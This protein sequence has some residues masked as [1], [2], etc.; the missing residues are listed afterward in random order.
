MRGIKFRGFNP[1]NNQWLYGF[2]LQNRGAHFVCPD[3]FAN[4]KSWDDYEV[5]PETVGQ[6]TGLTD[7][8][9]REIYDGDVVKVYSKR[10]K[11]A[12]DPY[13][14]QT[15]VVIFRQAC[16]SLMMDDGNH[17]TMKRAEHLY[18]F[19]IISNIHDNPEY[20]LP[21]NRNIKPLNL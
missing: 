13:E 12:E 19:E 4:G 18:D 14:G 17:M 11:P 2:Y 20:W 7:K 3:E 9:G 21:K 10:R 8:N 6:F 15:P 16:F 1:K 5:D